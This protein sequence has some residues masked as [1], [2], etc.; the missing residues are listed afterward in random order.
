MPLSQL[1]TAKE[2]KIILVV[3]DAIRNILITAKAFEKLEQACLHLEEIGGLTKIET[4]QNHDN[5]EVYR[6]ALFII[7][8]FFSE[9]VSVMSTD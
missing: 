4:L 3:L 6:K 2:P 9:E 1:L 5:E 8:K 7:E